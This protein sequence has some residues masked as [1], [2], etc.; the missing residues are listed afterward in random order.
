MPPLNT[1]LMLNNKI[2]QKVFCFPVNREFKK[3]FF[4]IH[5]D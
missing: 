5:G 4:E 3:I 1:P 2:F